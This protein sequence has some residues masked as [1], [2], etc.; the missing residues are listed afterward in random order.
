MNVLTLENVSKSYGEKVLFSGVSLQINQGQ[1][2]AL[3]AKNGKGKSTLLM[4]M[5]GLLPSDGDT[6]R[7]FINKDIQTSFLTQEPSFNDH[8]EVLEAAMDMDDPLIQAIK[9]YEMALIRPEDEARLNQALSTMDELKAWDFEAYVKELLSKFG[10]S[11]LNQQVGELSGGQKKRLA[12]VQMLIRKPDFLVLDEPTNHLD[13]DMIE[14]LEDYLSNSNLTVLMVTHDRYFLERVCNSIIELQNGKLYKY[15]GNYSDFLIRKTSRDINDALT[16]EKEKKLFKKELDWLSRQP[17]ARSTKAKSRVRS[18]HKLKEKLAQSKTEATMQM[19]VQPIRLGSKILEV[20]NVSKSFDEVKIVEFFS[21]K[22]KKKDR[23]GI[24]G[25]NGSGKSTLLKLLTRQIK[26]DNGKVVIG[27]TVHFGYYTQEGL[28]VEEDKRVIDVVRD[29][30]E[31]LPFGK[32]VKLSAD[33][34]LERFLFER[35]HQQVF[36]SRLSGGEKRRLHLLTILMK[37]PN[38]LILDEPTNDLDIITLNVLEEYL[39]DFPGVIVIVSHDRYFMDKIVDHIFVLDKGG[40]VKDVNGGYS[41]Y[42]K[43]Q[44][45]LQAESQRKSADKDVVKSTPIINSDGLTKAEK[46]RIRKLEKMIREGELEKNQIEARFNDSSLSMDEINDLSET[47]AEYICK[48]EEWEIEWLDL[49]E[50]Q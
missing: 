41:A 46:N 49:N 27:E 33:Q 1:K 24:V 17:K 7:L 12:L 47:L 13:L 29:I 14:W 39:L 35:S 42:R 34:L 2:V 45:Q 19:V 31:Y 44:K 38:F 10:F 21:Y 28:V 30:A 11:D 40:D 5:A 37:N 4:L 26:P 15:N 8:L 20:H 25:P 9:E 32:N 16:L 22:F 3:V 48:L 36:V 18:A 6:S 23:V 50:K 43:K